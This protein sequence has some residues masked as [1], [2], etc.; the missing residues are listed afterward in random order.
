MGNHALSN[1]AISLAAEWK[2]RAEQTIPSPAMIPLRRLV[3]GYSLLLDGKRESALPVWEEI[4]GKRLRTDFLRR[5]FIR[6]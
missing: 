1:L 3:L 2:A 4:A 5:R 6:D